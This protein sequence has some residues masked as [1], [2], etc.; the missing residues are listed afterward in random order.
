MDISAHQTNRE[1]LGEALKSGHLRSNL[2]RGKVLHIYFALSH[3]VIPLKFRGNWGSAEEEEGKAAS[4]N[5]P[6]SSS[7]RRI[8]RSVSVVGKPAVTGI[9]TLP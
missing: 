6:D 7:P 8:K 5:Y 4:S 3:Y 2:V 9:S 1:I